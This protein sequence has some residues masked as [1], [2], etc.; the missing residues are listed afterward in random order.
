LASAHDRALLAA[1]SRLL[2]RR[3]WSIFVVTHQTLRRWHRSMVRR[4]WTYPTTPRG[5]TP[6]P[7]QG[8]ALIVRLASENPRWG[9]QRIRWE[10]LRLGRRVSASATTTVSSPGPLMTSGARHVCVWPA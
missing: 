4:R 7:D 10:L 6:L 3:R 9:Y 1:L 5:R 2:P 8:A